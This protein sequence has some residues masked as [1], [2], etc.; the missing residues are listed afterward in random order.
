MVVKSG[1]CQAGSRA[2]CHTGA[3]LE[4]IIAGT[5]PMIARQ[6]RSKVQAKLTAKEKQASWG[7][8]AAN[9]RWLPLTE[10]AS[11]HPH[12]RNFTLGQGG[13]WHS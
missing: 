5:K 4:F 7:A 13:G 8:S 9:T 11:A 6:L 2:V 12:G 3:G 10:H 1:G